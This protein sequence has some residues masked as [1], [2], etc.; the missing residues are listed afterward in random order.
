MRMGGGTYSYNVFWQVCVSTTT[1][2]ERWIYNGFQEGP[3]Y[4]F[5]IWRTMLFNRCRVG[6]LIGTSAWLSSFQNRHMPDV[7]G[8]YYCYQTTKLY[9]CIHVQELYALPR[10]LPSFEPERTCIAKMESDKVQTWGWGPLLC[11]M[12]YTSPHLGSDQVPLSGCRYLSLC[13]LIYMRTANP[14]KGLASKSGI[15]GGW[16]WPSLEPTSIYIP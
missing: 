11:S 16:F 10:A 14:D 6:D 9:L 7:E 4:V 2:T 12:A 5:Y 3:Y 13:I 1:A 8:A 15:L